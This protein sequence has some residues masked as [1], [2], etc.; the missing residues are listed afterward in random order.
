[1][2]LGADLEAGRLAEVAGRVAEDAVA[3]VVDAIIGVW[4]ALRTPAE[5]LS[6]TVWRVGLDGFAAQLASLTDGFEPGPNDELPAD[7]LALASV[8]VASA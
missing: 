1:V 3:P 8:S 6:A 5:P 7:A 2:W 4:E